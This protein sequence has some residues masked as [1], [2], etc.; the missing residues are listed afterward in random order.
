MLRHI[1]SWMLLSLKLIN[2][3]IWEFFKH[4]LWIIAWSCFFRSS[5]EIFA[6][7]N[8]GVNL[9]ETSLVIYF[10][11]KH[12]KHHKGYLCATSDFVFASINVFLKQKIYKRSRMNITYWSTLTKFISRL[13]KLDN[14]SVVFVVARQGSM[15]KVI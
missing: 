15:G 7:F 13:W 1:I 9:Y 2:I 14:I 3:K 12:H 4:F 10:L 11:P 6:S 5:E 8:S